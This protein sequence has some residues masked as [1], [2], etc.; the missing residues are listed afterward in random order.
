MP[1]PNSLSKQVNFYGL[2]TPV[3]LHTVVVV[4]LGHLFIFLQGSQ[5]LFTQE[6]EVRVVVPLMVFLFLSMIKKEGSGKVN[7][8]AFT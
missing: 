5:W 7:N 6:T 4:G 8:V 1:E 3:N 2:K